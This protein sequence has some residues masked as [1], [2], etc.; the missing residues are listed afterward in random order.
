[1]LTLSIQLNRFIILDKDILDDYY[2]IIDS[3]VNI[4]YSI[5][6]SENKT[7][8]K[9]S[10]SL[11]G[12]II[13]NIY[14]MTLSKQLEKYIQNKHIISLILKLTDFENDEIQLNAFKIL[15]SITTEQETKN[16]VYSNT[17]A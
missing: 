6:Q 1:L 2:Q 3:F 9:L 10:Q 17:I 4:L 8:N 5:I 16:I 13:P 14:T 15:S 11:I 7:N 12:T